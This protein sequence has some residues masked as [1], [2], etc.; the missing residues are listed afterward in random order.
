M[1]Y[2]IIYKISPEWVGVGRDDNFLFYYYFVYYHWQFFFG[3]Y[4]LSVLLHFGLLRFS[5]SIS[6]SKNLGLV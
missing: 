2:I 5:L 6:F 4:M 1:I 3:L